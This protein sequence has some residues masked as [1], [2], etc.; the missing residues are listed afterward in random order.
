MRSNA[1]G[2]LLAITAVTVGVSGWAPGEPSPP[3][4]SI[5]ATEPT[6]GAPQ[7]DDNTPPD[8]DTT[9]SQSPPAGTTPGGRATPSAAATPTRVAQVA[10]TS[11]N[12]EKYQRNADAITYKPDLLPAG[13]DA[14]V[15]ST[16]RPEGRTTVLL[17]VHGLRPTHKYGA[18]VHQNSC[19]AKGEDA[20]PHFQNVP[21]PAQPSVNPSYANPRN[22]IW[23]DFTTDKDGNAT[24]VSSVP[25]RFTDRHPRSIVV[26][27][28]H[29]Q[30]HAGHAGAAGDRLGCVNVD[31]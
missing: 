28:E 17:T 7:D 5:P 11:A 8:Q 30:T 23:L 25:W 15:L 19:G 18:H 31:F 3:V 29:T 14:T 27:A 20:G 10:F 9:P 6:S 26:H 22:E 13:A 2:T 4:G 24:T 12:F 1:I 16:S 21:D